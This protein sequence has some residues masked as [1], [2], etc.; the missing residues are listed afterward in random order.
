MAFHCLDGPQFTY[1]FTY[2]RTSWSLQVQAIT[3]KLLQTSVCRAWVSSLNFLNLSHSLYFYFHHLNSNLQYLFPG[4]KKLPANQ[5]TYLPSLLP[6]PSASFKTRFIPLEVVHRFHFYYETS[7]RFSLLFFKKKKSYYPHAIPQSL[8]TSCMSPCP[9]L[10]VWSLLLH[11]L[12]FPR[13]V[14]LWVPL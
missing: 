14:T 4:L 8:W 12:F 6:H 7:Y 11:G 9:N 10:F 1:P 13:Y 3:I 5:W 2:W